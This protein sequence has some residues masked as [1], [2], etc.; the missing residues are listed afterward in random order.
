MTDRSSRRTRTN[1]LYGSLW[2]QVGLHLGGNILSLTHLFT[3]DSDGSYWGGDRTIPIPRPVYQINDTN[4][5]TDVA[6]QAAAAFAACSNLYASRALD[7][8]TFSTP[9]SLRDDSYSDTLLTHA[10]QLYRFAVNAT[11]GRKVYQKSVPEVADAYASS[12]YGDEL[13]MAALFLS[14]ATGNQALFLEAEG[15]WE[16]YKL[17]ESNRVYNW[18]SKVP[19]LPVLF[20]QIAKTQ[21]SVGANFSTWQGIAEDYFDSI[22]QKKNSPAFMTTGG[23]LLFRPISIR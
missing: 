1:L 7:N 19:A 21:P 18:D 5:G 15:Y 12:A 6:A 16:Q 14:W 23:L 10:Q 17:S 22:V 4:P 13:A 20:S 8:T 9:A 2:P 3:E 11:G